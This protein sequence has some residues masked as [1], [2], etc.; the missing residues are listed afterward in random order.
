M[1]SQLGKVDVSGEMQSVP[2]EA[3]LE[4]AQLRIGMGRLPQ[5][6]SA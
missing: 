2:L 3:I 6:V 5:Q 1:E 4:D